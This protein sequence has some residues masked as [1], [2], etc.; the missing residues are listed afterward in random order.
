MCNELDTTLQG[1][2][3]TSAEREE[4]QNKWDELS[5]YPI[6]WNTLPKYPLIPL[7]VE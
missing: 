5:N 1:K 3:R 7:N 2:L 4:L 6:G